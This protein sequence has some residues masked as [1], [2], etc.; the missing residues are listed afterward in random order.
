MEFPVNSRTFYSYRPKDFKEFNKKDKERIA[1]I[2]ET[3]DDDMLLAPIVEDYIYGTNRALDVGDYFGKLNKSALWEH[4]VNRNSDYF[5]HTEMI[6]VIKDA[7]NNEIE[8]Y[9][10]FRSAAMYRDHQSSSLEN[11]IGLIFDSYYIQEPYDDMHVTLLFGIDKSKSPSIA[12]SLLKYP[13]RVGTSMGCK[14]SHSICCVCG[15]EIKVKNDVCDHIKYSRGRRTNGK[16]AAELLRGVEFYEDSVVT[17]PAAPKSL[18][19]DVI[20]DLAQLVPGRLLKIASE[21]VFDNEILRTMYNIRTAITLAKT[22]QEK[23]R[24]KNNFDRIIA[25]LEA[26]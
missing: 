12:R 20:A 8:R 15:K 22:P 19:I 3:V 24:L 26:A 5:D 9:L 2:V 18:V 11:A 16:L 1:H 13:K 17:N 23:I 10:T 14:I 6:D 7:N 21:E 4:A 25:K